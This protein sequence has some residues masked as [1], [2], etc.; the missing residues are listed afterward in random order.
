MF[1]TSYHPQTNGLV[2]RLNGTLVQS[3]SQYVSCDQ[4]DWDEHLPSVLLAYR[5]SP[6]EVTS[7]S[8]FFLLY[9]REP[10]L[11]MDVSLLPP[12]DLSAS[13]ADHRAR[14]VEH[15]ETAQEVARANIQRAQQRM[16]LLYDQT[17]NFPEYDLGQQVWV[18]SPKTKRGLIKKL[19][20]LWHG[21]MRIYQKFSPV[22]YKVK[23]PN[24]S[25]IATTIHINRMKPYYDSASRPISPPEEDD[26]SEPYLDE[27]ELPD[28]SFDLL[29]SSSTEDNAQ[30]PMELT[31]P[32]SEGCSNDTSSSASPLSLLVLLEV[33]PPPRNVQM[34]SIK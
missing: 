19:R 5:V 12:K 30:V 11:P 22:T 17:S 14:V 13:I 29:T 2:E 8:P 24:N 15:L 28:D 27:S 33:C 26:P 6:S 20:H 1:T 23:L 31:D 3:L 10:R 34:T 4:K 21:P 32:N 25:R 9:G 18:Y 16:K 7:D